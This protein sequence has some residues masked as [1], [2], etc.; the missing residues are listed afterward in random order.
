MNTGKRSA[1]GRVL[2]ELSLIKPTLVETSRANGDYH[3]S[4][5]GVQM[6]TTCGRDKVNLGIM[7]ELNI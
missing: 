4:L 1:Y 5:P 3:I 6:V 2:N 7:R